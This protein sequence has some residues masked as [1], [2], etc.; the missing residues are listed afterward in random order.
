VAGGSGNAGYVST[1]EAFNPATGNTEPQANMPTA[2]GYVAAGVVNG[3]LYVVGGWNG[4]GTL[5]TTEA[6]TPCTSPLCS[7]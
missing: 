6:Y 7:L 2:R 4:F 3:L 5:K 1:L